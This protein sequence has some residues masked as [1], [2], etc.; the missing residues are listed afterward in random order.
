M[1]RDQRASHVRKIGSQKVL[2]ISQKGQ[3]GGDW[4]PRMET[5]KTKF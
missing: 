4:L 5:I 1:S 2:L 3:G